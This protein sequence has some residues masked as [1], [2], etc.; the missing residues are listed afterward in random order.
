MTTL[1]FLSRSRLASGMRNARRCGRSTRSCWRSTGTSANPFTASKR[2]LAGAGPWW[3]RWLATS[4]RSSRGAMA[5]RPRTSG[6][7][8]SS[9]PSIGTSQIS[10]RWL[11]KSVGRRIWSSCPAV[12]ICWK[13]N[14]T[15]APRPAS[16]GPRPCS[17]TRSTT[18]AT[19]NTCST[20]PTSMRPCPRKSRRRRRWRSRITTPS[21]F[22]TWPRSTPSANWSGPWSTTSAVFSPKW[23]APSPLSAT[24]TAW[25]SADR[26]TS[27]TSC[28]STAAS[29]AW[30]RSS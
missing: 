9:T 17:S 13:G 22:S 19:R 6:T 5:S 11:E 3:R 4:R 23:A 29:A 10:N 18:R 8:A 16:A 7:C 2:H 26:N 1:A 14:S 12:K 25:R 21:I 28:C 30:W 24:S 27:L 15:S 20:R